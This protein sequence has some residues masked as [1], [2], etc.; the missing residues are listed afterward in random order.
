MVV[1]ALVKM[2][3]WMR[4]RPKD[5]IEIDDEADMT[6]A[7]LYAHIHRQLE[8]CKDVFGHLTSS[9]RKLVRLEQRRRREARSREIKERWQEKR[10]LAQEK[11]KEVAS[12]LSFAC[13]QKLENAEEKAPSKSASSD[14]SRSRSRSRRVSMSAANR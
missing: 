3:E 4:H 10:R 6:E 14:S 8:F 13:R 5:V 9:Y 7:D 11:Q 12:R 1:L 2:A